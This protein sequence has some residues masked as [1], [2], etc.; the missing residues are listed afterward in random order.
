MPDSVSDLLDLLHATGSGI[1]HD[2]LGGYAGIGELVRS[3]NADAAAD[4]V[5][6]VQARSYTSPRSQALASALGGVAGRYGQAI[7]DLIPE[8]VKAELGRTGKSARQ[9]WEQF[10]SASP[11][12]GAALAGIAGAG[13]PEIGEGSELEQALSRISGPRFAPP[14]PPM[15]RVRQSV[16][17]PLR[18]AAPGIYKDP[19][20]IAAQAEAQVT[21]ES[22][23]LQQVW[24]LSRQDIYDLAARRQGNVPGYIP[25]TAALGR[26]PEGSAAAERVRTPA[27]A[28]RLQNI[29][30]EGL[31]RAPGMAQGMMPWYYQDP[32]YQRLRQIYDEPEALRRFH[33]INMLSTLHSPGIEVPGEIAR[34]SAAYMLNEQ[35]RYAD[36]LRHGGDPS[37]APLNLEGVP[38]HIYHSTSQAMPAQQFLERGAMMPDP[39]AGGV[40]TG[41]Y[42]QASSIPQI[43][44]QTN[45]PIGDV[46][47]AGG[48]ALPD[49]RTSARYWKSVEPAEIRQLAPWWRSEVAGPMGLEAVPAQGFQWGLLGPETGVK[50]GLG[51]PKLELQAN[52]IGKAA[53]R[54]GVSPE[55]ARDMW[56]MGKTQ[57]GSVDPD[58][59]KY[60]AGG[61]GAAALGA[62]AFEAT[63]G[64]SQ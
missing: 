48:I 30:G 19:R 54:L 41:P 42:G 18:Q 39:E 13:V 38:G 59:L 20:E 15:R 34:G 24:G 58:L 2:I 10:S 37:K 23:L 7:S 45:V 11:G 63:Q 33:M 40:K 32:V 14:E 35:G 22:P 47:W 64:Q 16:T 3:R 12:A 21:P 43:G 17:D 61:A 26:G 6:K 57:A 55:T 5:R 4:A 62:G 31:E 60:L 29:L 25:G 56:L 8:D 49:V 50:T 9:T 44:F 28:R 27:N 46:H 1:G 51:A 53:E 36:W 52:Q